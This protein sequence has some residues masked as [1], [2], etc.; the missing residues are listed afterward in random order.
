VDPLSRPDEASIRL[1]VMVFNIE[2]GGEGVDLAKVVEAIRVADPDIVALQEAETNAGRIATALGWDFASDRSQVISRHPIVEPA[3]GLGIYV[4]VEV[5]PGEVVA[6]ASVH[7]PAEPY[8]PELTLRGGTTDEVIALER[9]IRL[10]AIQ[11]HLDVL[12][13]RAAAGVPVFL[14]GDFNAP[15]H[16]DWT[17]RTVGSR[18]QITSPIDW[19]MSRAIEAAGFRDAWRDIHPDPRA[20]PGLTWWADRPPTGRYQPGPET[21]NDRIDLIYA[22]GP[23]A[24]RGCLIVGEVGGPDVAISIEPWPSDHRAVVASFDVVPAPM[25]T[26]IAPLPAPVRDSIP[27]LS[28]DRTEYAIGEPIEVTW[29]AGPGYRWDWIAVFPAPGDHVLD[30]HLIWR[31]TGAR[32]EGTVRLDADAAVRD[33][34][35]VGGH[36]PLPPGDYVAAYLL[37]DG[38]IVVA[39]AAFR[40]LG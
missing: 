15:S 11:A 28:L 7:P 13:G 38:P 39:R 27:R 31:H 29:E 25:P 36:W 2:E 5:R 18:P 37:D 33:Q 26:S 21:P 1:G 14:L 32:A 40:I 34:S 16:L 6:V 17:D 22:T 9:R 35:P 10:P 19:P 24:T 4:L 3:D 8:G 30:A 12:P 20:E 23:A